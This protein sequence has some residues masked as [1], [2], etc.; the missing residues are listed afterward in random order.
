VTTVNGDPNRLERELPEDPDSRHG[1]HLHSCVFAISCQVSF[2]M[3]T[4]VKESTP[5]R[6]HTTFSVRGVPVRLVYPPAFESYSR[7]RGS[8]S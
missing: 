7:G 6:S 2:D 4:T 3:G 1:Q 8:V 5:P